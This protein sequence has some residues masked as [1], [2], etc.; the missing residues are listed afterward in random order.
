[1]IR[2]NEHSLQLERS[3]ERFLKL[4]SFILTLLI[5]VNRIK[6][7][8]SSHYDPSVDINYQMSDVKE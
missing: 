8:I 3:T 5:N 2:L 7:S 4:R 6:K 1:M